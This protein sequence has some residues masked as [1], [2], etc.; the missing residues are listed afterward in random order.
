MKFH[1]KY[2][3]RAVSF[4][5]CIGLMISSFIFGASAENK[6]PDIT[7]YNIGANE[8][9]YYWSTVINSYL[10]VTE[11][12]YMRLQNG[13]VE[14][15]YLVEYYDSA[16]NLLSFKLIS[17]ELPVFGG[18]YA[19]DSNYF[20]LSGQNNPDEKSTVE[21]FRITKYDL[22]WNRITSVGLRDCNTYIPFDAGNA[23]WAEWGD[24]LVIRTAHEMYA[25]ENG[26]HHQANVTIQ[27]DMKNMVITDE[28]C[29][30]MNPSCGYVSHSFNQFIH[31]E[32]GNIIALDHGDAVP[33]SVV[34]TKYPSDVSTGSFFNW[35]CETIDAIEIPGSFGANYTGLEIGGFEISDTSYIIGYSGV[36]MDENY[37]SYSTYNIYVTAVDKETSAITTTAVTAFPEGEDSANVPHL[38]KISNDSF[39]LIWSRGEDVYYTKLNGNGTTVGNI[40]TI[41]NAQLSDCAPIVADGKVIWYVYDEELTVFYDISIDNLSETCKKEV[42]SGHKM[43]VSSYPTE[44]GGNCTVTCEKCHCSETFKTGSDIEIYWSTEG[45]YGIHS[46]PLEQT[47]F[48]TGD[49]LHVYLLGDDDIEHTEK[50]IDFSDKSAVTFTYDAENSGYFTFLKSGT[51]TVHISYLYNPLIKESYTFNVTGNNIVTN[52]PGSGGIVYSNG[53]GDVNDNGLIDMTDYILVKRAYFGTYK[54]TDEEFLRADINANNVIDMTDYILLKRAYFGT[55]ILE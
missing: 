24:Y 52:P 6:C 17:E 4:L 48:K 2:T 35:Y 21:C 22:N 39:I 23:R 44:A 25:D 33:R 32:N 55:Y 11:T 27:L 7:G 9:T 26:I 36:P 34:I 46:W 12:G 41:K 28:F 16:Y 54:L 31:I 38:V 8:Y 45:E 43:E 20:I 47:D 51:Y 14:G 37:N 53:L 13:A 1:S 18:F 50:V 3:K 49:Q 30:V 5:I 15:K 40:H 19:T 10:A 29:E 42:Y